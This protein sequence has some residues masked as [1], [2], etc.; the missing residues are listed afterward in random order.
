MFQCY[1]HKGS[2][3][4]AVPGSGMYWETSRYPQPKTQT[5]DWN[6]ELITGH[7]ILERIAR[8]FSHII[9]TGSCFGTQL[10]GAC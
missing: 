8:A 5:L 10:V 2:T 3:T 1:I 9:T 4:L 7:M 6:L